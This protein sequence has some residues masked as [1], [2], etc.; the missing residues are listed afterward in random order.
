[1][2]E[3]ILRVDREG[4]G[5]IGFVDFAALFGV[6]ERERETE[7]NLKREEGFGALLHVSFQF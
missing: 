3:M 6:Q 1:V 2:E 5:T 7:T 4:S